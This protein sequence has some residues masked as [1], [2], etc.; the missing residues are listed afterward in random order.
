[1]NELKFLENFLNK[2]KEITAIYSQER[3]DSKEFNVFNLINQI[4]GIG[5]TKHSRFLAFLLNPVGEHGQGKLFLNEFLCLLNIKIDEDS[6]WTVTAEKDNIDILLK[7][8]YP[9]KSTI[10]IENKSNWAEDQNN[11]LYRYWHNEIYD[12]NTDCEYKNVSDVLGVNNRIIYLTP[13]HYKTYNAKSILRPENNSCKLTAL[14]PENI[15]HLYFYFHIKEWLISCK[16]TNGLPER[17]KYFIDDYL[18]FWQE[19]NF[20]DK[21]YIKEM[22]DYFSNKHENWVDF[23]QASNHIE[24]I[25]DEWIQK[26]EYEFKSIC[27]NGWYYYKENNGDLRIYTSKEACNSSLT[28]FVYEYTKGLSIWK[29]G[30]LIAQKIKYKNKINAIFEKI[31]HGEFEFLNQLFYENQSY[32][33]EY[34]CND[35][36]FIFSGE[37]DFAWNAGNTDLSQKITNV[38]KKYLTEEVK[39]LFH[40]IDNDLQ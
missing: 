26:M 6:I 24:Q 35:R 8:S 27:K 20:K 11:Q 1:M 22:K 4:Y 2:Y 18:Q 7:S 32:I 9:V 25:T 21:L 40:E 31:S 38:F 13:N 34:S 23:V 39:S 33:M 10:I 3:I 28:C 12:G 5:E 15:T 17:I 16:N 19:T 37:A 14:Y 29:E 36:G 30:L